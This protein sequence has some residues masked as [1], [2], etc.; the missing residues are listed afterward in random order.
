MK[1]KEEKI[2]YSFKAV[3]SLVNAV[4]KKIDRENLKKKTGEKR[5][6]M[7]SKMV[8]LLCEFVSK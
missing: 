6:N 7:S 1:A 8:E 2:T 5:S 4:K 3:P